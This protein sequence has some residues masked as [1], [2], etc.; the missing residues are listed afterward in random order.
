MKLSIVVPIYNEAENLNKFFEEVK[1]AL[2][3][4]NLEYEIIAVDDG[5]TDDSAEVLKKEAEGDN[6]I[7]VINFTRN[8]G[9]T[10]AMSAGFDNAAGEIVIP[11]D[12]DLQNDPKDIPLLLEKIDQGYDIVSGWRK[13]RQENLFSR[14]MPSWIANYIISKITKVQLHDYGCTLKAYRREIFNRVKLYGEMHRFIPALAVWNGAKLSEVVVKDRPRKFGKTKYGIS[15]TFRVVLDLVTV[16]LLTKYIAKPMH[17]FGKVGFYSMFFSFVSGIL[18]IV[19]RI[20]FNTS[21]I[22]TPLPL[23]TVFL[24]M[25]GI[26]F[27]LM[28]LLAEILIRIYFESQSKPIYHVKNK[29]NF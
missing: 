2:S 28:G 21:L 24:A 9:Q 12:A 22:S 25:V 8:F 26:Q 15:R 27:I 4:L 5:S 13:N 3:P 11:I 20:Y 16:K 14:K 6:L 23:L 1:G 7:R 18:A 17:F 29:I 19:F 10:A